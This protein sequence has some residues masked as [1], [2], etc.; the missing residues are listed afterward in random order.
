MYLRTSGGNTE[1]ALATA[2]DFLDQGNI[3]FSES[4]AI[5]GREMFK[6]ACKVGF[7]GVISKV[8]DSR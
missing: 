7:E 4:F 1:S 3:Q 2:V 6:H 8:R 5:D